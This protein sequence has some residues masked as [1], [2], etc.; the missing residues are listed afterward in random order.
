MDEPAVVRLVRRVD[1]GD[2]QVSEVGESL[3]EHVGALAFVIWRLHQ[4]RDDGGMALRG[5]LLEEA[6]FVAATSRSDA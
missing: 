2:G 6:D 4:A 5:T 1:I 3:W